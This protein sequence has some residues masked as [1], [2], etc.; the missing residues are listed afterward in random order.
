MRKWRKN[1]VNAQGMRM[2]TVLGAYHL[3][4]VRSSYL[5]K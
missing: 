2:E 3:A 4:T 1:C 5:E